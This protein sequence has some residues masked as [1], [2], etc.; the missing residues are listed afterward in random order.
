MPSYISF[1]GDIVLPAQYEDIRAQEF[2]TYL[3]KKDEKYGLLGAD[4]NVLIPPEYEYFSVNKDG[5][6]V[7]RR[8]GNSVVAR[9][10]Q[11]GI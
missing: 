6:I 10:F 5:I 7:L 8:Q 4:K 11:L 3:V 1:S 9:L 2:C